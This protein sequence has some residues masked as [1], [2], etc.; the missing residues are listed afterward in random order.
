MDSLEL[1]GIVLQ[2][3]DIDVLEAMMTGMYRGAQTR[4]VSWGHKVGY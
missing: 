1:R 2:R 4:G 3:S